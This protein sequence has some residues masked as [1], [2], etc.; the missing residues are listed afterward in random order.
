[1][2]WA[3]THLPC[4]SLAPWIECNLLSCAAV[5]PSCPRPGEQTEAGRYPA[6]CYQAIVCGV[7]DCPTVIVDWPS[8]WQLAA[9]P[10]DI[11]SGAA[12]GAGFFFCT[13]LESCH[14]H[15]KPAHA[16][17]KMFIAGVWIEHARAREPHPHDHRQHNLVHNLMRSKS[18]FETP[19]L[20]LFRPASG[21][22]GMQR[23]T[24]NTLSAQVMARAHQ[25]R[26]CSIRPRIAVR[27]SNCF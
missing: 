1:M 7:G 8:A 26:C 9:A 19:V 17:M 20:G 11:F 25:M 2:D 4:S 6:G 24:L 3:P 14:A 16:K 27:I 23:A 15:C 22:S 13:R 10:C 18:G 21:Y 5:K 12:C